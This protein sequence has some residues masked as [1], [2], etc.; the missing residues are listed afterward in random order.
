MK[1]NMWWEKKVFQSISKKD[2]LRNQS[3]LRNQCFW[4]I[5]K[6]MFLYFLAKFPFEKHCDEMFTFPQETI[7]QKNICILSRHFA[8]SCKMFVFLQEIFAFTRK[9]FI[10]SVSWVNAKVLQVNKVSVSNPKHLLENAK[11]LIHHFSSHLIFIH[12]TMGL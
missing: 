1:N 8:F 4:N 10:S 2:W 6:S 11:A 7:F 12:I 3:T 9:L 5:E